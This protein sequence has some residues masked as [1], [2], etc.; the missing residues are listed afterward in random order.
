VFVAGR[1]VP[2]ALLSGDRPRA[3]AVVDVVL[4]AVVLPGG[5]VRRVRQVGF[6]DDRAEVRVRLLVEDARGDVPHLAA[7]LLVVEDD[8]RDLVLVGDLER[9]PRLPVRFLRVRRCEHDSMRVPLRRVQDVFEVGLFRLRRHSGRGTGAHRLNEDDR[10]FGHLRE[11][12]RF[13]HQREAAA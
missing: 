6:G 9:P 5:I 3:H 2:S 10:R 1:E 4:E 7:V 12:E 8:R 13:R 11:A